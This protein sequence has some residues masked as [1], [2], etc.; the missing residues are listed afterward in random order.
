MEEDHQ[1]DPNNYSEDERDQDTEALEEIE[2][3][4]EVL[5][6]ME[7]QHINFLEQ[8]WE[9]TKNDKKKRI[10]VGKMIKE[11]AQ[12]MIEEMNSLGER[13]KKDCEEL[14]QEEERETK[15]AKKKQRKDKKVK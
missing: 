2:H 11:S 15:Q 1:G 14:D 13:V 7:R 10:E 4:V 6:E 9:S 5:K 12:R 3:I 8:C